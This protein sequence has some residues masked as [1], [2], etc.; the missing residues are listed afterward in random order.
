MGKAARDNA[1]AMVR[2]GIRLR[3]ATGWETGDG[4]FGVDPRELDR[5]ADTGLGREGALLAALGQDLPGIVAGP[6]TLGHR[7]NPVVLPAD[8]LVE[9][10]AWR[11][12][13]SLGRP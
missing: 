5:L 9:P 2:A 11:A 8:P 12:A 6:F 3:Y 7:A 13:L 1:T 4:A 10:T